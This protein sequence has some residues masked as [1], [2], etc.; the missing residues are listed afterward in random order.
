MAGE[1]DLEAHPV[2]RGAPPTLG[3]DE[4]VLGQGCRVGH[5]QREAGR[6]LATPLR[7]QPR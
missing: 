3:A 1:K 2:F 5:L 4:G 6:P 7:F